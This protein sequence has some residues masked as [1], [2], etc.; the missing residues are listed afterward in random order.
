MEFMLL[1]LERRNAASSASQPFTTA[2]ALATELGST[3]ARQVALDA[4]T[5]VTRLR[6]RDGTAL[7]SEVA[8]EGRERL[9]GFW[10]VDV[11]SRA[12]AIEIARRCPQAVQ[13]FVEVHLM[14]TR[15]TYADSGSG[16]PYL[17]TFH[18]EPEL[19]DPN[20]MKYEQMMAFSAELQ[21]DHKLAETAPL[22]LDPPPARV[23]TRG[24]KVLVTD[25]PFAESKEGVGGY[26]LVRAA[27]REEALAIAQRYPHATW[28]P[29]EVREARSFE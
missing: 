6:V 23:E 21:R 26:G 19:T 4:D 27:S 28:G 13:G 9:V 1:F 5:P 29:L 3:L 16:T 10:I 8:I 15:H 25:G 12:D 18:R 2:D 7:V 14:R 24:G 11:P 17:F 20:G 22:A